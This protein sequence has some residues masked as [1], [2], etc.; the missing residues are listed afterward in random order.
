H[1]PS[2]DALVQAPGE[3]GY[4][5]VQLQ[6]QQHGGYRLRRQAAST[7]QLIDVA[8]IEP[9]LR[10]KFVIGAGPRNAPCGAAPHAELFQPALSAPPQLGPLLDE[11]VAALRNRRVDRARD[12]EH[13]APLVGSEARSDQRP[14][15]ERGLDDQAAASEPGD[16]AVA[17]GEISGVGLG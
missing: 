11:R 5:S 1:D 15:V 13:L 12:G 8:R 3:A 9:H 4:F 17:P 6:F 16:E 14:R 7:Y 10:E 2:T